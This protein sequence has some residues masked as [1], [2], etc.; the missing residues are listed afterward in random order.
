MPLSN[1]NKRTI[2]FDV[3]KYYWN[4]KVSL[5]IQSDEDDT[6]LFSICFMPLC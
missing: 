6:K 2:I 4:L 5:F 3:L 1:T